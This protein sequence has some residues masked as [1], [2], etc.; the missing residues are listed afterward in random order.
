MS[1]ADQFWQYADEAIAN[2]RPQKRNGPCLSLHTHGRKRR[3][4]RRPSARTHN[5]GKRK[6][7]SNKLGKRGR[8]LVLLVFRPHV[9]R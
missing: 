7:T 8:C 4:C 5:A 1:E 6:Q 9:K 3:S 2:P